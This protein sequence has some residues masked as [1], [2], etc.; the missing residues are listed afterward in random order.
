MCHCEDSERSEED[1]AV[2]LKKDGKEINFYLKANSS[3]L[4]LSN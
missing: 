1:V 2:S 3:I 4:V